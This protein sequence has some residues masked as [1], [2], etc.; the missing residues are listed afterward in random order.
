M[1]EHHTSRTNARAWRRTREV[2]LTRDGHT[3]TGCGQPAAEVD[4]ITRGAGD[5]HTNLTSLC[6]R[7][8]KTKTHYEALA[9]PRRQ[10][11]AE[12]HPGLR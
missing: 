6:A 10:R 8:H 3:C 5:H 7:C 4:H 2:I 9:Q 1:S 12:P 11:P